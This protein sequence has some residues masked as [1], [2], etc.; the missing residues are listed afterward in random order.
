VAI[1]VVLTRDRLSVEFCDGLVGHLQK[2][3]H[4]RLNVVRQQRIGDARPGNF[5]VVV[6]VTG[7]LGDCKEL[8]VHNLELAFKGAYRVFSSDQVEVVRES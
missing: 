7:G 3:L 1:V 2:S 4:S 8:A 6:D 5:P